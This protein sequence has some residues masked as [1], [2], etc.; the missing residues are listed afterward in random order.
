MISVLSIWSRCCT[1]EFHNKSSLFHNIARIS[2]IIIGLPLNKLVMHCTNHNVHWKNNG[3]K[4]KKKKR[5]SSTSCKWQ[6]NIIMFPCYIVNYTLV[7]VYYPSF[8]LTETLQYTHIWCPRK[9][10]VSHLSWSAKNS[11]LLHCWLWSHGQLAF[12]LGGIHKLRHTLRGRRIVTLCDKG[13]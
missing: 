6:A 1:D 12:L 5:I 9:H 3:L 4:V 2:Y 7:H 10:S 8:Y 13:G 11:Y